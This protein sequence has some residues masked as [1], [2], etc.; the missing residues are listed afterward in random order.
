M[1][2]S[3]PWPVDFRRLVP[4]AIVLLCILTHPRLDSATIAPE[5]QQPDKLAMIGLRHSHVNPSN[6]RKLPN[7]LTLEDLL[8][9][10]TL[11]LISFHRAIL[12][13]PSKPSLFEAL[14]KIEQHGAES[15]GNMVFCR[16]SLNFGTY[17][18]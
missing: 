4:L 3:Q 5:R 12:A 17:G 16:K 1:P 10:P 15:H 11:R 6:I 9:S 7:C 14:R 2:G 13:S 18:P 8:N